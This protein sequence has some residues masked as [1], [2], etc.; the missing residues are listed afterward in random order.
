MEQTISIPCAC[1]Q[2]KKDYELG[3]HLSKNLSHVN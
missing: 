3:D 1:D 2:H